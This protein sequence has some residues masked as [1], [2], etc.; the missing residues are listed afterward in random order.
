[1]TSVLIVTDWTIDA[2]A[3][4]GAASARRE[5]GESSFGLLVP[6]WLHGLDWTGD[7]HA[8]IPCARLQLAELEGL[9]EAA[10]L[11]VEMTGVGDPDP[12]A[13]IEDALEEWPAAEIL[14]CTRR[15]L[16]LPGPLALG[17]RVRRM[18]GRP[19]RHSRISGSRRSRCIVAG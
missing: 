2:H 11:P 16:G 7:P 18:T 12:V 4:V 15:R 1:M 13:A 9:F 3:V 14:L 6:A 10:G 17:P 5:A 19:V 8:S